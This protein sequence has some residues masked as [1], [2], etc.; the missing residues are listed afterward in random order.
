MPASGSQLPPEGRTRVAFAL[1]VGAAA[2]VGP[3]YALL[4]GEARPFLP[5]LGLGG[6]VLT[7]AAFARAGGRRPRILLAIALAACVPVH[8]AA[9]GALLRGLASPLWDPRLW[10]LDGRLWG[11]LLP[12][13]QF[14]L[15]MDRS[16]WMGPLTPLGRVLTE[17]FQ[18]SYVSYYLW[19]YGLLFLLLARYARAPTPDAWTRV[20]MFLAAWVG[21]Y[22]LNYVGYVLVPAMG[23][24]WEFADRFQHPLVGLVAT[25]PLRALIAENQ[26]TPDCFPSGH[27]AL[28][29]ITGLV[30][31][32]FAP[33][34]GRWALLAAALI[35]LSTLG[36]RYHYVVDLL[37]A[38]P[39]VLAGLAW[40]GFLRR[41]GPRGQSMPDSSSV[42]T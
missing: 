26:V 1:L 33:R 17:L 34:Y 30:A 18:L 25:E 35:T 39:L 12:D 37:A 9:T 38:I 20:R 32:R 19:G 7:L 5:S 41:P 27:T 13:G 4:L 8:Y 15:W 23:P 16:T 21:A 2:L 42:R 11:W 24:V 3:V 6:I 40:G 29:W 31:L 22:V 28:S 14:S 36:L 10:A